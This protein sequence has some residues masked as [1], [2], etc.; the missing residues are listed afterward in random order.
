M[1]LAC[2]FVLLGILP[3]A[4]QDPS[5]EYWNGFNSY[6]SYQVGSFES[7]NLDNFNLIL[8]IPIVS[9][10]REA[11]FQIFQFLRV[12]DQQ[13][14]TRSRSFFR[15]GVAIINGPQSETP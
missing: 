7:V 15:T 12:T 11:L 13:L 3:L 1:I 2:V 8:H 5:E 9:Y 6:N 14:G 10:P 4:A